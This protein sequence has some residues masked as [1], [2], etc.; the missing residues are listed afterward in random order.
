MH[1][2]LCKQKLCK[3]V[4]FWGVLL[5]RTIAQ[6]QILELFYVNVSSTSFATAVSVNITPKYSSSRILITTGGVLYKNN[7][8]DGS[9]GAGFFVVHRDNSTT[10]HHTSFFEQGSNAAD[11]HYTIYTSGNSAY[12]IYPHFWQMYDDPNTTSQVTYQF[13]IRSALGG[14][15]GYYRGTSIKVQELKQ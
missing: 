15:I 8:S 9:N 10:S 3:K 4:A 1:V 14:N 2:K 12:H 5:N 13:K 7:S 11:G 6:G